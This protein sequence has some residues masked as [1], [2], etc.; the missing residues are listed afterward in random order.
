[1]LEN[2]TVCKKCEVFYDDFIVEFFYFLI[3][4]EKLGNETTLIEVIIR[5]A[6]KLENIFFNLL[7]Y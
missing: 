3:K 1:M 6:V 5:K 4:N 2:Y 7:F